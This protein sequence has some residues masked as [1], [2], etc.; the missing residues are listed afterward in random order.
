MFGFGDYVEKLVDPK[1]LKKKAE[2]ELQQYVNA[3][4]V[5]HDTRCMSLFEGMVAGFCIIGLLTKDEGSA[6]LDKVL[7]NR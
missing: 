1:D 5:L 4:L 2:A 7:K 6:W 3:L